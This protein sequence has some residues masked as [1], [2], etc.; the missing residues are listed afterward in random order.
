MRV[1]YPRGCTGV[2]ARVPYRATTPAGFSIVEAFK[3]PLKLARAV[4]LFAALSFP[5]VL[6]PKEFSSRLHDIDGCGTLCANSL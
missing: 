2:N 3:K 5:E 1:W 6:A 4:G